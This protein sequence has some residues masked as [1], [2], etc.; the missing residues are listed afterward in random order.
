MLSPESDHSAQPVSPIGSGSK[1]ERE[2]R[3]VQTSGWGPALLI[4]T[5]LSLMA[6]ICVLYPAAI[7][8]CIAL[9]IADGILLWAFFRR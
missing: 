2:N 1:A 6:F 4:F 9:L 7:P 3:R 5:G 8:V